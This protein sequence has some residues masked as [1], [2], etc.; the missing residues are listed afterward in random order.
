MRLTVVLGARNP[1]GVGDDTPWGAERVSGAMPPG[2]NPAKPFR[3]VFST[4][5]KPYEF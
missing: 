3:A 1:D 4:F 2:C 5:A